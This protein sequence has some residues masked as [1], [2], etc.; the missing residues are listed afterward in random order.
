MVSYPEFELQPWM[1]EGGGR[2]FKAPLD[3]KISAEK[4]VFIVSSEK[5]QI[6]PLLDP[7]RKILEIPYLT[8]PGK[9]TSD[10]HGFSTYKT[11][12]TAVFTHFV[13]QLYK[14]KNIWC[15]LKAT[16]DAA[17]KGKLYSR[18]FVAR[19]SYQRGIFAMVLKWSFYHHYVGYSK[20]VHQ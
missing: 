19:Q 7:P 13:L 17:D 12:I 4:V 3:L 11:Y 9:N 8:P 15:P 20:L 1:S 14:S 6:S 5:K 18:L 10:A 2:R 16:A